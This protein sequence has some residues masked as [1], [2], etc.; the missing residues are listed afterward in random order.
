MAA[1]DVLCGLQSERQ[2]IRVEERAG[3]RALK[4]HACARCDAQ[5]LASSGS[6]TTC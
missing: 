4:A 1:L 2:W 5:R 3:V 6:G